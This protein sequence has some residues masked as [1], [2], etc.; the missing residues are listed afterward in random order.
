MPQSGS[1]QAAQAPSSST[2]RLQFP[3]LGQLAIIYYPSS[4]LLPPCFG[5]HQLWQELDSVDPLAIS[6]DRC[7]LNSTHFTSFHSLPEIRFNFGFLCCVPLSPHPPGPRLPP[8]DLQAPRSPVSSFG[9]AIFPSPFR[10]CPGDVS[11]PFHTP[12]R[13]GP[14]FTSLDRACPHQDPICSCRTSTITAFN[15]PATNHQQDEPSIA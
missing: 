11:H 13:I 15:R 3:H 2:V 14:H 9:T 1:S 4:R 10:D 6:I 12:P 7:P 5:P 8:L